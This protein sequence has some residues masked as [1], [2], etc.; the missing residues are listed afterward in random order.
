MYLKTGRTHFKK[1]DVFGQGFLCEIYHSD[2]EVSNLIDLEIFIRFSN[3]ALMVTAARFILF[4]SI[5]CYSNRDLD[6]TYVIVDMPRRGGW[7]IY[8]FI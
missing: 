3:V 2:V 5:C 8:L 1:Q 7:F 4:T 6:G